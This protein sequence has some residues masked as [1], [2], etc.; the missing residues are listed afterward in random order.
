MSE[1]ACKLIPDA[2]CGGV[3]SKQEYQAVA[4]GLHIHF[5]R[6][7]VLKQDAHVPQRQNTATAATGSRQNPTRVSSPRVH[8]PASTHASQARS[9]EP[10]QRYIGTLHVCSSPQRPPR[11]RCSSCCTGCALRCTARW[12]SRECL[13]HPTSRSHTQTT[14]LRSSSWPRVIFETAKCVVYWYSIL[15]NITEGRSSLR[16]RM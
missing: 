12:A 9:I 11:V 7:A 4:N 1:S 13:A 15:V 2:Q 3:R 8:T 6:R 16:R 5:T 10:A 14:L